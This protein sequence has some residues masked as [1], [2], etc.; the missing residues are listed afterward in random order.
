MYDYEI[1]NGAIIIHNTSL[2]TLD[3]SNTS[4]ADISAL[5]ACESLK[6][7]GLSWTPVT[8]ISALAGCLALEWLDLYNTSVSDTSMLPETCTIYR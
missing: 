7:L 1:I 3:L 2:E 5:A 6:T 8:D 4:V